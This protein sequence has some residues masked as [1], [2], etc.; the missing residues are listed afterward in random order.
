MARSTTA[1]TRL[2]RRRSLYRIRLGRSHRL[3]YHGH[4]APA[5]SADNR[6]SAV[7]ITIEELAA[8]LGVSPSR[9]QHGIDRLARFGFVLRRGS[10]LSVRHFVDLVTEARVEKLSPLAQQV[11]RTY[12]QRVT[13]STSKP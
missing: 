5:G 4:L 13:R 12:R 1:F 11:D 9:T 3:D 7:E 6:R 10:T 2:T 8:T